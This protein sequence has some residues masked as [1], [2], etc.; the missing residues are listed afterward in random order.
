MDFPKEHLVE[1]K[2]LSPFLIG[3]IVVLR[4][5]SLYDA[6]VDIIQSES[7]KIFNH[8]AILYGEMD[9]QEALNI[10]LHHLKQYLLNIRN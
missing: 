10:G 2:G 3:R 9:G 1:L 7:G 5:D 6:E 4:R 8:V